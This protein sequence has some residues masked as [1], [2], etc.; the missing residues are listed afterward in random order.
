VACNNEQAF[1]L[2]EVKA[3]SPVL[4][5][6]KNKVFSKFILNKKIMKL[7]IIWKGLTKHE[8]ENYLT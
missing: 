3:N 4:S 6:V 2:K 7:F 8:A 5:F 1:K